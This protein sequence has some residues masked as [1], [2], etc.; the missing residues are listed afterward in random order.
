M[1][2]GVV[3]RVQGLISI[4]FT[5]ALFAACSSSPPGRPDGGTGGTGG[6]GG[7]AGEIGTGKGGNAGSQA[8][9]GGSGGHGTGG[10]GGSSAAGASGGAGNGGLAGAAGGAGASG[11]AGANGLA[12]ASGNA[13]TNGSG[14][15]SGNAGANGSAGSSGKAGTNG[16]AG[17]TGSA[18]TSGSGGV[19]GNAGATGSGGSGGGYQPPA[20]SLTFDV[21]TT[22]DPAVPGGRLLYTVTVGN[23]A[24]VAAAGVSVT[25]LL[26][27]G[28]QFNYINDTEPNVTGNCAGSATCAANTQ[29][30]WTIGALAAGSTRTIVINAQVLATVGDG[31]TIAASFKLSATGVNPQTFVK[32]VQVYS[33]SS[34]QLSTGTA[35]NP[36]TPGQRITLDLDV[37][38]IGTN[39]LTGAV[40]Q[41]TVAPGLTVAS[42]SD[43]GTQPTPGSV[44]WTI[45]NLGV[46]SAVHRTIDLTL[47]GNVPAGAILTTH[48][49]L[50]YDGGLAI[51]A[52]AD[53]AI[54]VVT[55]APF[56][57]V[58]VATAAAPAASGGPFPYTITVSNLSTRS[59]DGVTVLLRVPT[60]LQFNYMNDTQP[61]ISGNCAGSATCAA[62]TEATWAL[63][64]IPAGDSRRI[65]INPQ[66]LANAVGN[67]NLIRALFTTGGTGVD[68][69]DVVKTV[70]VY[71]S[72]GAQLALG[73]T[74]NPVTNTQAFTYTVDVGQIGLS[75]LTNAELR[76]WIPPGLSVGAISSGGTQAA[77]GEIDW[78]IGSISVGADLRL[79][80]DVTGDGSAPP[81]TILDARAALTYD[82]GAEV[83]ALTDYAVSV[84]AAPQPVTLT[85]SVPSPATPGTRLLYTATVANTTARSLDA[86]Q[87][88]LRVPVGLQFNYINDAEPDVTG[89]CNGSATCSAGTEAFWSLGT[90]AAGATQIITINPQVLTSLLAGSLIP[91]PFWLSATGLD[92][93]ILLQVVVPAN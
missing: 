78:S 13:G 32:T 60:G 8:G 49:T 66:V 27:V 79:T 82:G 55:A 26:P 87:L 34:A 31:D 80:V 57:S 6:T 93:P 53:Y 70:Q 21:S 90:M 25:W 3:S 11:N 54:R 88:F 15:V 51:D 19:S 36:A 72:P 44:S 58:D 52:A 59:V 12:G 81:G 24:T 16:S 28:L 77:T 23:T 92:A 42:V 84:V 39:A 2:V 5:A 67:G 4:A 69:L 91:A 68:Q 40:L 20:S 1:S 56:L 17:T 89:N 65:A 71:N 74:A 9:A 41:A 50:T 35:I 46:G 18:G 29:A 38:Q 75:T 47:D 10:A 22:S 64:S 62:N 61:D 45:G 76:L 48:A 7:S 14:G 86:V 30:T 83:D 43:G 73:A 37:G 85:V 63:G 33:E